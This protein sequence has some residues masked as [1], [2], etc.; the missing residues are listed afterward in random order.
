MTTEASTEKDEITND[1]DNKGFDQN[2]THETM[3]FVT[4]FD[5]I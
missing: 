4:D 5:L 3:R 1:W 2:N